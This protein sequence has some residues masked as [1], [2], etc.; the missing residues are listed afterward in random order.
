MKNSEFHP[1]ARREF[2]RAV[3]WYND[4][5]S[6]L[7]NRFARLVVQ[8][9]RRI[10]RDP[11]TGS[12]SDHGTCLLILEK[13]PYSVVHGSFGATIWIVAVAHHSRHPEYWHHRLSDLED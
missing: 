13:F 9:V 6:G 1:A 4:E 5:K 11:L 8:A 3:D 10:E 12:P 7:G 2:H